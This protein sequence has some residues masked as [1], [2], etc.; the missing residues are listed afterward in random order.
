MSKAIY[1][2][3]CILA[4]TVLAQTENL[5]V[6]D[7]RLYEGKLFTLLFIPESRKMIISLAGD[8]KVQLDS[9]RVEVLGNK[10]GVGSQTRSMYVRPSGR[11]F[12]ITEPFREIQ[13]H[14]RDRA[15]EKRRETFVLK[16]P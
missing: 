15:N 13:I 10:P 3:I 6:R 4:S 5:N 9:S 12:E 2:L 1:I 7:P 16:Q 14:I 8:P 11:N